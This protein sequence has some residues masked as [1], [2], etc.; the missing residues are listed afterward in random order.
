[1]CRMPGV[2]DLW[3][4]AQ[5][6]EGLLSLVGIGVFYQGLG[7]RQGPDSATRTLQGSWPNLLSIS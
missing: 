3:E 4:P 7:A 1:M 5:R 2:P 6:E